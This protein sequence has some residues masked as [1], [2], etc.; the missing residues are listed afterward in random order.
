MLF[1][2]LCVW[3]TLSIIILTSNL[4]FS[5]KF[6]SLVV[7]C[8]QSPL[9]FFSWKCVCRK[10]S[11]CFLFH[12]PWFYRPHRKRCG[13]L[14]KFSWA[15]RTG[16]LQNSLRWL[17]LFT[18]TLTTQGSGPWCSCSRCFHS[19]AHSMWQKRRVKPG[20]LFSVLYHFPT[21]KKKINPKW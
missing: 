14:G 7:C 11:F 16:T 17:E 19:E 1:S 21:F 20:V 13:D 4:E 10:S 9:S 2:F 15:L 12:P 18:S 5:L 3:G 6:L 8:S